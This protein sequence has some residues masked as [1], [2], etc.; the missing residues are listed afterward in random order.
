MWRAAEFAFMPAARISGGSFDWHIGTAGSTTMLALGVLPLACF[1]DAP[2]SARIEGAC[3][4]TLRLRLT[5]C[6]MCSRRCCDA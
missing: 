2:V 4:R 1:A 5:I 3:S 6:N